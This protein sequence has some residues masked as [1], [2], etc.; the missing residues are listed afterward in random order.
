MLVSITSHVLIKRK[1]LVSLLLCNFVWC[2]VY[3]SSRD[4]GMSNFTFDGGGLFANRKG[5][6][7]SNPFG[8]LG[9]ATCQ[10]GNV[11]N[12]KGSLTG[13]CYNEVECVLRRG[14]FREY[15]GPPAIAG[16]CCIFSTNKCD[17]VVEE[18]VSYFTNPSYP[19]SDNEPRSC[20]L[21]IKPKP[22]TCWVI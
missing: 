11:G 1:M 8:I 3:G 21:R 14:R 7:F 19:A 5:R 12:I 17:S 18:R 6:L 20:M 16:V 15:C 2:M 10:T 9:H 13:E 4:D 22:D